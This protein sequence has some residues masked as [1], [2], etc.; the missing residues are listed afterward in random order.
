MNK[1]IFTG[2]IAPLFLTVS[3]SSLQSLSQTA[4]TAAS[5]LRQL[6]QQ[7]RN[8]NELAVVDV[9]EKDLKEMPLGKA[10]A[11]AF[12]KKQETKP[13]LTAAFPEKFEEPILP[14]VS[15]ISL[16]AGLLPPKPF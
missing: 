11:L 5:T 15:N 16:D 4:T 3:C 13:L 8:P 9:R 14:D 6:S 10:R 2:L 1:R 7:K 12:E